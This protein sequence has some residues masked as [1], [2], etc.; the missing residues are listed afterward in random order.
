MRSRL[1]LY[2]D[3]L[4]LEEILFLE[5]ELARCKEKFRAQCCVL[6]M[7][8]QIDFADSETV[9]AEA[10]LAVLSRLP[11]L[12]RRSVAASGGVLLASHLGC[13]LFLFG[14]VCG[15]LRTVEHLLRGFAALESKGNCRAGLHWRFGLATG[16]D[17]LAEESPRA[18]RSSVLVQRAVALAQRAAEGKILLD[19]ETYRDWPPA[20]VSS[21]IPSRED[22]CW[23]AM[24]EVLSE[25][26]RLLP[27]GE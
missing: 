18:V 6:A 19:E 4:S 22:I 20:E 9:A 23:E 16:E 2:L 24:P 12:F 27:V 17:C 13:A 21:P 8:F 3:S 11:K 25:D 10:K 1:P 14:D 7:D 26:E 5:S 15:A